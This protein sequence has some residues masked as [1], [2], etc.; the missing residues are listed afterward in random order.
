MV[1][2][3]PCQ[4]Q[5]EA[6]RQRGEQVVHQLE[7]RSILPYSLTQLTYPSTS[8]VR[9]RLNSPNTHVAPRRR[10]L[11]WRW[12]HTRLQCRRRWL[13]N[14][15]SLCRRQPH[16]QPLWR[17]YIL[18]WCFG[19]WKPYPSLEPYRHILLLYKRSL[20]LPHTCPRVLL[21]PHPRSI[22]P[23]S[24]RFKTVRCAYTRERFYYSADA[25]SPSE[26]RVFWEYA[27]GDRRGAD[28]QVQRGCADAV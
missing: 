1:A 10:Y 19:R 16:R 9:Q 11:Q 2:A 27:S 17:I 21:R 5:P 7:V 8:L 25:G 24:S 20:L 15:E 23:D 18:R 6:V 28:A 14:R 22:L 3:L 26:Q 4:W 12:P 13:S